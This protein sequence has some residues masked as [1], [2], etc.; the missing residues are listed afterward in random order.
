MNKEIKIKF[1][2]NNTME[3]RKI[4]QLLI[5]ANIPYIDLGPV[6]ELQ[7]ANIRY[8]KCD[9][10]GLKSIRSFIEEVIKEE[11]KEEQEKKEM[12]NFRMWLPLGSHRREDFPENKKIIKDIDKIISETGFDVDKW[13]ETNKEVY[14]LVAELMAA[15]NNRS[16]FKT[17]N[18][19][20]SKINKLYE[21][22]QN[23]AYPIYKRMLELGYEK[24]EITE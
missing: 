17:I 1:Y 5:E 24:H 19:L 2:S 9:Y 8:G 11:E 12:N 18:K 14:G 7:T 22:M 10:Y 15:S 4:L 23:M 20:E 6:S 3:S 13:E 16:D 21:S